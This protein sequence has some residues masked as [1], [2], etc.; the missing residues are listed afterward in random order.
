M[1]KKFKTLF[2][3]VFV[4]CGLVNSQQRSK[5][6]VSGT[7]EISKKD[8]VTDANSMETVLE[9]VKARKITGRKLQAQAW[10]KPSG[11]PES[12]SRNSA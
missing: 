12:S 5:Y 4:C 11:M 7:N 3:V 1:R 8:V 10:T 2:L 6:A 9:A